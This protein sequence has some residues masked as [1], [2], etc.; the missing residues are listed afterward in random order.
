MTAR[1]GT[2]RMT[3]R[4][5][6]S[7][8]GDGGNRSEA[9]LA[10][11]AARKSKRK[12]RKQHPILA[13]SSGP[14]PRGGGGGFHPCADVSHLENDRAFVHEEGSTAGRAERACR[15]RLPWVNPPPP[16]LNCAAGSRAEPEGGGGSRVC[17]LQESSSPFHPVSRPS[18]P[19]PSSALLTPDSASQRPRQQ[20]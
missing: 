11:V 20:Y 3:F 7:L 13:G 19:P 9:R 2:I 1:W 6:V 8:S 12:R 15:S 17:A 16:D 18:A 10:A 5:A 14:T 4:S